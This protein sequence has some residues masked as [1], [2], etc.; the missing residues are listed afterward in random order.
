MPEISTRS[1]AASARRTRGAMFALTS[2]VLFGASMPLC[3]IFL[4]DIKPLALTG[5]LYGAAGTTLAAWRFF[6]PRI[7]PVEKPLGKREIPWLL[8]SALSGGVAAPLLLFIGL[9]LTPASTS[10]LLM[11]FEIV[12]TVLIACLLFGERLTTYSVLG[13]SLITFGSVLLSWGG[14]PEGGSFWGI[15]AV[16]GSCACWSIDSNFSRNVS[17]ADP[18]EY[19]M[20]KG[21]I[22]GVA[23]VGMSVILQP[24]HIPLLT[25]LYAVL[26]GLTAYGISV[27]LFVY[28]LRDIG[29]ARTGGYFAVYTF[30]GAIVAIPLLGE[31]VNWAT[32]VAAGVMAGGVVLMFREN[33]VK[34]QAANQ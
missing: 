3:K 5:L 19:A 30:V 26:V 14:I 12:M 15:I 27:V 29:T 13:V 9:Q 7:L 2:A 23:C 11:N 10:S 32:A 22:G 4:A 24:A 16:L 6:A 18:V 34:G 28:S 25:L 20:W 31:S 33:P 21:L 17:H 1:A 8:G